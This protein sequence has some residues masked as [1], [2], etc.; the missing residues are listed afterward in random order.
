MY[1]KAQYS[2]LEPPKKVLIV[3][4]EK[5]SRDIISKTLYRYLGCEVYMASNGDDAF[6]F[7]RSND[8]DL[9]IADL[10]MPGVPGLE[11]IRRVRLTNPDLFVIVVTGNANDSDIMEIKKMGI[12]QIVYKPFKITSFLETVADALIEKERQNNFA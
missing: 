6:S 1:K 3:D 2:R 9:M 4:D 12:N 10:V 11:L 7:L 5:L 8:F